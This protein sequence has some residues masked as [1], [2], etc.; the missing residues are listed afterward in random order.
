M[1][2][3]KKISV[4]LKLVPVILHS[5]LFLQDREISSHI[6]KSKRPWDLGCSISV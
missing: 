4:D 3:I 2:E 5:G 1:K 6:E